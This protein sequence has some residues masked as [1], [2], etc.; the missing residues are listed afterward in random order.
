MGKY[1]DIIH[2]PHYVSAKHPQ[3]AMINRAAQFA[4]FAALSGYD[5]AIDETA[6]LTDAEIELSDGSVQ[7]INDQV[8]FLLEHASEHLEV[9]IIYFV[10][11][12]RKAG[13][14]YTSVSGVVKK[15]RAFEQEIEMMDGTVIAI[16]HILSID[17]DMFRQF[18][19][20]TW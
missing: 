2:L 7:E 6:R 9:T 10:P 8:R 20:K 14:K 17:G 11:D 18:E 4:P 12:K 5:D 15:V 16:R 3:M 19:M 13:G 1:D